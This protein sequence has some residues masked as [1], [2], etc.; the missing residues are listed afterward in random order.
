MKDQNVVWMLCRTCDV[1][2]RGKAPCWVCGNAGSYG[3]P[4]RPQTY[5]ILGATDYLG[6]DLNHASRW[7]D[8]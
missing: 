1:N 8:Q 3:P 5:A 4:P 2:W 7:T 6:I